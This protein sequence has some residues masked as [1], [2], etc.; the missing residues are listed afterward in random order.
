M[1]NNPD[2][3]KPASSDE[4]AES[5]SQA[6]LYDRRRRVHDADR[7]IATVAAQKLVEHLAEAGY[8]VMKSA[9]AAPPSTSGMPTPHRA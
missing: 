7:L 4:I 9:G 3:L 8:V 2:N 1:A 6:L 5:L